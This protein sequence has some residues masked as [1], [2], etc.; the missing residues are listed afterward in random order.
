MTPKDILKNSESS[1]SSIFLAARKLLGSSFEAWEPES[2]WLELKD[3][4][5]DLSNTNRDKLLAAMTLLATGSYYWDAAVF[6]N[7]TMA[8]EH[9]WSSPE[10]LQEA[11]PAQMA[12]AVC[13]AE[14]L[15]HHERLEVGDFDY[16]PAR[17]AAVSLHRDG[18]VAAPES[19][20][21]AQD[22][23]DKLNRG[24]GVDKNEV[25]SRWKSLDKATLDN[26]ELTETPSDVQ[27]AKL[28]AVFM[29]IATRAA[30]LQTEWKG[31]T[32]P[33]SLP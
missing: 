1:A 4:G 27:I 14:L 30:Q 10:I 19:L 16:E 15:R 17:Y 29:H 22:A 28:A 20:S 23:L 3:Q 7:T 9:E 26:L 31:L 2:I 32:D 13:E 33:L 6:E 8:F 18:F 12:W 25:L 11:S 5:A 21:F 24:N